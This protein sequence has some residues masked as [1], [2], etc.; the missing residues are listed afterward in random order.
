MHFI[1]MYV[2]LIFVHCQYFQQLFVCCVYFVGKSNGS[3]QINH[4]S[5]SLNPLALSPPMA[6]CLSLSVSVSVKRIC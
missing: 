3:S 5:T 4:P 1:L 2:H 6:V